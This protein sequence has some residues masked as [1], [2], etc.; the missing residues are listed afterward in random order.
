MEERGR[1]VGF[2]SG[3]IKPD[4]VHRLFIWQVAV[5][6]TKRGQG[7]ASKMLHNLLARNVCKDVQYIETTVSPSNIPSQ[8][9]FQKLARS[10]NTTIQ[11]TSFLTK[12]DFPD[13][14]H[15]EEVWHV[16]GPFSNDK[17]GKK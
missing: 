5:D 6:A 14:E 3:F 9:L 2:I 4:D 13:G 1:I 12:E 11:T 17:K 10:L 8:K 7:I 15:E 16:I